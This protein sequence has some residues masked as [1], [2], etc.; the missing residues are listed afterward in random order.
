MSPFTGLLYAVAIQETPETEGGFVTLVPCRECGHKISTTAWRCPAC[1]GW[2]FH[3]PPRWAEGIGV[4]FFLAVMEL[5]V[6]EQTPWS[7]YT[8][9]V[10]FGFLPL[11]IVWLVA[12]RRRH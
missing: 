1:G 7:D 11:V 4:F 8:P 3:R 9:F 5:A 10:I 12:Q 6:Y 2:T